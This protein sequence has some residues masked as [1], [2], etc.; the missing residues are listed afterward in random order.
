MPCSRA[1][2]AC[3][4]R[5]APCRAVRPVSVALSSRARAS[6]RHALP[7]H[8]EDLIFGALPLDI[9]ELTANSPLKSLAFSPRRFARS[10]A[11]PPVLAS[12]PS[13]EPMHEPPGSAMPGL[14]RQSTPQAIH[15][16]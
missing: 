13:G 10:N 9:S 8:A 7:R 6:R 3:A 4:R 14:E 15:A 1:R 12:I 11:G 5:A 2:A 16:A